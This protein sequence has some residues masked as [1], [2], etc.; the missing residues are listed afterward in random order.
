MEL[1]HGLCFQ[2]NQN[3]SG[4]DL[5]FEVSKLLLGLENKE[6]LQKFLFMHLIP[7]HLINRVSSSLS[8][9]L[10]E[11]KVMDVCDADLRNSKDASRDIRYFNRPKRQQ[12]LSSKI[13][14]AL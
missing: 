4:S 1:Y 14:A 11:F 8:L 12:F 6:T 5:N 10:Q 13:S 3:I 7:N 9:G 2:K